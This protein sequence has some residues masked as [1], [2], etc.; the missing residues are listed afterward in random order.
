MAKSREKKPRVSSL[1]MAFKKA[2]TVI[3]DVE[4]AKKEH[5]STLAMLIDDYKV[6][7]AKG[8]VEGIR[9]AKELVE[10]IKADLL[11]MG[12]ATDRTESNNNLDEVR[13]Q[14]IY[15]ILDD[16][17]IDM[18]DI[19]GNMF[20]KMNEINDN[21]GT[22]SDDQSDHDE[23]ISASQEDSGEQVSLFE[24]LEEEENTEE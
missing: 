6:K 20:S 7:L 5:R 1:T 19:I 16:S 12:E 15:S 3:E 11:L 22:R 17:D 24:D 2:T 14:E 18:N 23:E 13:L 21:Y 8:E 9:N 10:V 4:E